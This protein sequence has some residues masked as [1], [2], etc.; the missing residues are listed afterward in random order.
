MTVKEIILSGSGGVLL[1]LTLVQ[2]APVKVNPWSSILGWLG[3]QINSDLLQK[4]EA[5][6]QDV[7]T[8]KSEVDT[9]R[10]ENRAVHA[11][12]CRARILRF[13]DEIYLGT[14]HSQEHFKQIMGDITHYTRYCDD[15]PEFENQIAV[16]AIAQIKGSYAERL[17]KHDF[18]G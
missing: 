7:K 8:V 6:K 2:I 5:V 16:V 14:P 15:H 18:L 1:L 10:D 17:K 13:A 3:K 11:K 9:I 12:D 4:L